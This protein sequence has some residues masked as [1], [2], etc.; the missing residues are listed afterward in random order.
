SI[1]ASGSG[2]GDDMA[3]RLWDARTGQALRQLHGHE[4]KFGGWIYQI[5]FAPDGRTLVFADGRGGR[6]HWEDA[7]GGE[8]GGFGERPIR[9]GDGCFPIAFSPD[10]K[11]LAGRERSEHVVCFWDAA[12]RRKIQPVEEHNTSVDA[13]AVSPDGAVLATSC[14]DDEVV[15]LW[16][17]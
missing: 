5:A 1:L 13:L 9:T 8:L 12:T 10:G 14:L 7:T 2:D 11:V 4:K 3:I 16:E 15:R 6:I 17:V